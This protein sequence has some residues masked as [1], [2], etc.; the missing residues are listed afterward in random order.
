MYMLILPVPSVDNFTTGEGEVC[1]AG[2][3]EVHISLWTPL[4]AAFCSTTVR[5]DCSSHDR[6]CPTV[7]FDGEDVVLPF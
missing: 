6:I 3:H 2:A 7:S 5:G 1:V 4:A